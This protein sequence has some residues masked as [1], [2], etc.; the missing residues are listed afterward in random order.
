MPNSPLTSILYIEDDW[1]ASTLAKLALE[2]IGNF[3]VRDCRSGQAA[4]VAASFKPDLILLDMATPGMDGLR[5]LATLRRFPHLVNTPVMFVTDG[6]GAAY[7]DAG[8]AGLLARPLEPMRLAA[9]LRQLWQQR[10]A[11]RAA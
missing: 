5:T 2:V 6:S 1:Q 11:A 9:Q 8:A 4:F 3:R 10:P 7:R